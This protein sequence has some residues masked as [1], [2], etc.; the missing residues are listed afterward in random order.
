MED[1]VRLFLPYGVFE[2]YGAFEPYGRFKF[3]CFCFFAGI[4]FLLLVY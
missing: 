2:S 1:E 3:W 4:R